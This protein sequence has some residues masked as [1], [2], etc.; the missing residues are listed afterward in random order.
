MEAQ[1]LKYQVNISFSFKMFW[2]VLTFEVSKLLKYRLF[3]WKGDFHLI[4]AEHTFI[5]V[6]IFFCLTI[7]NIPISFWTVL[8]PYHRLQNNRN[9][10]PFT[11]FQLFRS[12]LIT[13]NNSRNETTHVSVFLLQTALSNSYVVH[14]NSHSVSR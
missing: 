13:R 12:I 2:Y 3:V 9:S 8:K 1:F 11:L 10:K 6:Y 4:R 7:I 14:L 5:P